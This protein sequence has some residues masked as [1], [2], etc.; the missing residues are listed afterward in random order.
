M[1]QAFLEMTVLPFDVLVIQLSDFRLLELLIQD[2]YFLFL[3]L[4]FD[5]GL[6]Y[7]SDGGW[8]DGDE[9]GFDVRDFVLLVYS[10][11]C[12]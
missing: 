2:V 1:I 12:L 5:G 6:V 3:S 9:M 7:L 4:Y 10:L 8:Y 11:M